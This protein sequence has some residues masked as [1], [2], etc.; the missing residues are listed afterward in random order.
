MER[1]DN[2]SRSL[3]GIGRKME[4]LDGGLFSVG[5]QYKGGERSYSSETA[6]GNASQ[7]AGEEM[8]SSLKRNICVCG[9]QPTVQSCLHT[10]RG[11]SHQQPQLPDFQLH[12]PSGMKFFSTGIL[13][14][15]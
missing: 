4:S 11:G 6:G 14:L 15:I 8:G 12:R 10:T 13:K 3:A 1:V 9:S 5:E 2:L 7:G